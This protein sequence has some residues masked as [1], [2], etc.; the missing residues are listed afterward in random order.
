MQ[1]NWWALWFILIPSEIHSLFVMVQY[2]YLLNNYTV[3]LCSC[4]NLIQTKYIFTYLPTPINAHLDLYS[5]TIYFIY[6]YF[7]KTFQIHWL[8]TFLLTLF[9]FSPF[10]F[11]TFP[12]LDHFIMVHSSSFYNISVVTSLG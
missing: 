12:F 11:R 5:F 4:P 10:V 2:N 1:Q 8:L 7:Q 3:Y 9:F 6:C